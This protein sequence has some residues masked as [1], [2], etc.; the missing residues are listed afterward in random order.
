MLK[1]RIFIDDR[2]DMT[3]TLA[4]REDDPAVSRYLS[5]RHEKIASRV[6]LLQ[7]DDVRR[8]VR[9]DVGEIRFIGKFNDKHRKKGE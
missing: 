2:F 3:S 6:V 8:H 4:Y 9:V 5:S 7:E 1:K